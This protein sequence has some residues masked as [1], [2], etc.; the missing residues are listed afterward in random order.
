MSR[1]EKVAQEIKREVGSILQ[2]ELSDPR[3]GFVTVMRVEVTRDLQLA[4]IYISIMGTDLQK[5]KAQDA[6][7]SAK[8]LIRHLIGQK[9]KLRLT[10]EIIFKLD[11]SVE[12]SIDI[13]SKIERIKDELKQSSRGNSKK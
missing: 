12:Y 13:A 9:L 8:G 11:N 5:R 3:L 7:E 10:P 2:T 4:K 6:L 1:I